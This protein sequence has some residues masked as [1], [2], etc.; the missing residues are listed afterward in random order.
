MDCTSG[1]R[2]L[3]ASNMSTPVAQYFAKRFCPSP[4]AAAIQSVYYVAQMLQS[5]DGGSSYTSLP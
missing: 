4:I 2:A 3:L 5:H 1:V